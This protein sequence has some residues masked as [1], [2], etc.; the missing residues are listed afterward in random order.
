MDSML[1][2]FV[3][4]NVRIVRPYETTFLISL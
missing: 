3:T 1:A 2:P 4:R